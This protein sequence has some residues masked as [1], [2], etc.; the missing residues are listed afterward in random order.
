MFDVF[1]SNDRCPCVCSAIWV[2]C[3]VLYVTWESHIVSFGEVSFG[4]R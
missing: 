3:V 4:Y 1:S 2:L